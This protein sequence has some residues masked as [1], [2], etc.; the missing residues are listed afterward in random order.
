[1]DWRGNEILDY[2]YNNAANRPVPNR[3]N[4]DGPPREERQRRPV[5][6]R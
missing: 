1:M 6:G 4:D 5:L 3:K 2:F